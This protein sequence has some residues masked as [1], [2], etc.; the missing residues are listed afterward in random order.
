MPEKLVWT[1]QRDAQ[2]KRMRVEGAA[3]D[4]IATVLGISRNAA[5]ERGRVTSVNEV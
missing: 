1:G 2:L 4:A 3:W 5:I